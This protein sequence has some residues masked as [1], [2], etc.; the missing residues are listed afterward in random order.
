MQRTTFTDTNQMTDEELDAFLSA[1]RVARLGSVRKDGSPHVTP[2][3]YLWKHNQ[4][5]LLM[6]VNRVHIKAW[7]R[8]PRASICIDIDPRLENGFEAGAMGVTM[9]CHVELT[10]DDS[11][12]EWFFPEIAE[13]YGVADDPKYVAARDAEPR[14]IAILTPEVIQSWDFRKG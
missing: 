2:V 9:R 6:G 10:T 3:W 4:I 14:I 11:V 1:P 8:D 5:Y 7:R 12:R 13:L